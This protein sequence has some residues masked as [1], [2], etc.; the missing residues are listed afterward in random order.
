MLAYPLPDPCPRC[1]GPVTYKGRGRRPT[2]CSPACKADA[3]ADSRTDRRSSSWTVA[4]VAALAEENRRIDNSH[5][6]DKAHF[7]AQ[8]LARRTRWSGRQ[9]ETSTVPDAWMMQQSRRRDHD[10]AA[11]WLAANHPEALH[12]FGPDLR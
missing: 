2:Y 4:D 5:D 8:P 7:I 12:D 11:Q 10:P 1:S 9:E 3:D 6:P